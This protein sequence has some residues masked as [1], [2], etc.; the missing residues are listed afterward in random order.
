MPGTESAGGAA[1]KG[2]G[3][4]F[5]AL[6]KLAAEA[7]GS[8]N[9]KDGERAGNGRGRRRGQCGCGECPW[10]VFVEASIATNPRA[11]IENS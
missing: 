2:V 8:S 11:W 6:P 3:A 5:D 10:C 7:E 4:G 1:G 9:A